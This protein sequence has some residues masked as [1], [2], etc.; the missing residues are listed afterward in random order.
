MSLGKLFLWVVLVP[1]ALLFTI[2]FGK[3]IAG[4]IAARR[5]EKSGKMPEH[6]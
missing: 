4:A 1:I 5:D 3:A 2:S 6:W